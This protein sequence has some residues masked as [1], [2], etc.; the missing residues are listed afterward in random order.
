[1]EF[2]PLSKD[3]LKR[4]CPDTGQTG[5]LYSLKLFLRLGEAFEA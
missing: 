1:M 2:H 4:H 3:D 5:V